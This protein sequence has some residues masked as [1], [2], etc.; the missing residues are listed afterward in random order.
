MNRAWMALPLVFLF[1][2][3]GGG[4]PAAGAKSPP[5]SEPAGATPTIQGDGDKKAEGALEPI[6]VRAGKAQASFDEASAAFTA[7]GND[8]AQ[9]CKALGSMTRATERLCEL[10]KE[11]GDDKRCNDATTKLDS[12]RTKVKSSCGACE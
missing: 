12:A 8:C 9:L 2:C 1:A 3:G 10:A 11:N 7:A 5:P 6:E 4:A